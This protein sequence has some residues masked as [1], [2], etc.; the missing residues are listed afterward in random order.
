M[1]KELLE[2]TSLSV[3]EI[4]ERVGF[5]DAAHFYRTFR[6]QTSIS[7]KRYRQAALA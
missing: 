7:P 3:S 6:S 5:F 1:A 2:S 4:M